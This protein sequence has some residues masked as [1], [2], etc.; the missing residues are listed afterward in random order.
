LVARRLLQQS[1]VLDVSALVPGRSPGCVSLAPHGRT[2]RRRRASHDYEPR[3]PEESVVRQVVHDHLCSFLE[4]AARRC[5]GDSLPSFVE[6]AF[7]RFLGCG[8]PG[9]GFARFRCEDCG[10]ERLVP[11]S[12]KATGLC[13]SC[14]GR[15]MA[16]RAAHLV[17]EILPH[18]PVRQWVLSLPH[19]LRYQLAYNHELC[20]AVLGV[21]VRAL[22]GFYQKRA[23]RQGIADGRSGT[24]SAI[25]RFGS[26]LRLNSWAQYLA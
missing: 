22:L 16:E 2:V 26:G 9:R 1:K 13:S 20:R 19:W 15:R 12:C 23:Q 17:D 10:F 25:M 4:E 14:G 8:A 24:F 11:Y 3:R 6:R 21:Y 5:D 7:R 18:A